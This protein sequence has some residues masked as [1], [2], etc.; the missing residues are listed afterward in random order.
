[1]VAYANKSS[2]AVRKLGGTEASKEKN[3]DLEIPKGEY[4]RFFSQC[5]QFFVIFLAKSLNDLSM[6]PVPLVVKK[7][8]EENYLL[9]NGKN[10]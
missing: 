6:N 2:T 10:Q 7:L 8:S 3:T 1:M 9:K 5:Y 4:D